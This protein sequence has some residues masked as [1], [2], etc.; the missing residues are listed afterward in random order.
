MK[1]RNPV[2]ILKALHGF[3]VSGSVPF[4]SLSLHVGKAATV[5]SERDGFVVV[6]S[7]EVVARLDVLTQALSAEGWNAAKGLTADAMRAIS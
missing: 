2:E 1:S 4:A 3:S 5:R 7:G 6:Y